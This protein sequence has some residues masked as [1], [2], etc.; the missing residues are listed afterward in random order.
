MWNFEPKERNFFSDD[1]LIDCRT[2]KGEIR[3]VKVSWANLTKLCGEDKYGSLLNISE[4]EII[5]DKWIGANGLLIR[6]Y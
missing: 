3:D 1:T 4:Y 2:K 5:G 6:L